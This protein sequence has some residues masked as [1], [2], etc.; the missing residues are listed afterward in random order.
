M[1]TQTKRST[2]NVTGISN[3]A[4]DV[5]TLLQSKLDGI[6]AMQIYKEDAERSNDSEVRKLLDDLEQK[7][8][9]EITKLRRILSQRL[10]S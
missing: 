7:E 10:S 1:A 4:Y 6:S 5:L 8:M 2:E 3:V 9:Q